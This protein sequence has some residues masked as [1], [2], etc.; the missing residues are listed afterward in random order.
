M[1]SGQ[2]GFDA[3]LLGEEPIE[4]VVEFLLVDLAER[5]HGAERRGRSGA[6][7]QPRGGELGGWIEQPRH[8]QGGDERH[9][10]RSL[11]SALG[12]Q[13]VEAELAQHA[14]RGRDMAVG[15][16]THEL[17][18]RRILVAQQPAQRFD[19]ARR[20]VRDVGQRALLDLAVLAISLPQQKSRWRC[21][22]RNPINVH[23][24]RESCRFG[25]VKSK[26]DIY[27]GTNSASANRFDS[28]SMTYAKNARQLPLS[29]KL[30][31]DT[32]PTLPI[33]VG[34]SPITAQRLPPSVE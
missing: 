4:G 14:E 25:R 9:H 18:V 24:S 22:I 1:T 6:V 19:L 30:V 17:E 31:S 20:P 8:H 27:L 3:L 28:L 16:A 33:W 29:Q 5:Q 13:I 15:Q 21:P 7:E 12:Q 23:D 26:N 10:A 11:S 32:C 34:Q 2:R